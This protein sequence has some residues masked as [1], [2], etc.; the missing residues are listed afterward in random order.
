MMFFKF[1]ARSGE[2]K[3]VPGPG[4]LLPRPSHYGNLSK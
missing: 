2:D 4:A 1:P 3:A